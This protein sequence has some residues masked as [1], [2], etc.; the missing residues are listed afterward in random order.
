MK[1]NVKRM[2]FDLFVCVLVLIVI[3]ILGNLIIMTI[4]V[5]NYLT[6]IL[7]GFITVALT[8]VIAALL[9]AVMYRKNVFSIIIKKQK[10][11]RS[12]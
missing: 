1:I 7:C 11:E 9:S 5:T 8:G 3:G 2:L 12:K 10:E 4:P 6:W